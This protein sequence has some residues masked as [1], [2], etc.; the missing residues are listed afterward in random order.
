MRVFRPAA[1]R[2]LPKRAERR[3][4][5]AVVTALVC[6]LIVVSIMGSM[7]QGAIRTRRQM[8][9][10]RDRRQSEMLLVAGA[11][12][13]MS[14]LEGNPTFVGDVW[15]LPADV[16][17]GN[18]AGRVTCEIS[19]TAGDGSRQLRVIAEYPVDRD[20]PIRRSQNFEIPADPIPQPIQEQ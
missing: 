7:I 11:T 19:P 3:R 16:I 5:F 20:F 1:N 2:E 13:A 10:E 15:Q 14:R 9:V 12:R 8:H 4:G 18:G 17:V 6:L